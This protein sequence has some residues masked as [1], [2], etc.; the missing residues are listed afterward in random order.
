MHRFITETTKKV[1]EFQIKNWKWQKKLQRIFANKIQ[2]I[3]T[4]QSRTP[5]NRKRKNKQEKICICVKI[6]QKKKQQQQTKISWR[7]NPSH[8]QSCENLTY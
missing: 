8:P 5:L 3:N 2:K 7:T 1:G 6:K 4:N